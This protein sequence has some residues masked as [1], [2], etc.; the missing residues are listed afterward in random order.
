MKQSIGLTILAFPILVGCGNRQSSPQA[1]R[2]QPDQT[3]IAPATSDPK[4][5]EEKQTREILRKEAA[6]LRISPE[7]P[8]LTDAKDL[9]PEK[10]SLRTKLKILYVASAN[11]RDAK[12]ELDRAIAGYGDLEK[13]SRMCDLMSLRSSLIHMDI[14]QGRADRAMIRLNKLD[15]PITQEEKTILDTQNRLRN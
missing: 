3:E 2:P 1:G 9:S 10:E 7:D 12:K 13:A 11:E 8:V 6:F 15:K 4:S 5:E 14:K